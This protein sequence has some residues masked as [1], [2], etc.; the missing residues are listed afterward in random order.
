[1]KIT[2][3]KEDSIIQ[4]I[5]RIKNALQKEMQ[6]IFLQYKLTFPQI[7]IIH[8]ISNKTDI[9]LT[10]VAK[11]INL[12]NS[13]T[14]DIVE[15]LVKKKIIIK[16]QSLKDKRVFFLA[17]TPEWEKTRKKIMHDKKLFWQNLFAKTDAKTKVEIMNGLEKLEYLL[18]STDD[19]LKN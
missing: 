14:S 1:M 15:R 4:I 8:Y 6:K 2:Q 18:Q 11:K 3:E 12:S 10:K 7:M 19:N 9:T 5:T 16:I 13:T 17:L